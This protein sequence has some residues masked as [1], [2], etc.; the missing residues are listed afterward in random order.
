MQQRNKLM[1]L[2]L[3]CRQWVMIHDLLYAVLVS[4]KREANRKRTG[5]DNLN[6]M[7]ELCETIK[8]HT[9]DIAD[10]EQ[11]TISDTSWLMSRIPWVLNEAAGFSIPGLTS[12]L[13][14]NINNQLQRN[15]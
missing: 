6:R 4:P 12:Q 1:S 8:A 10:L 5:P 3:T 7:R 2:T 11:I 13:V 9:E 15:S 14:S